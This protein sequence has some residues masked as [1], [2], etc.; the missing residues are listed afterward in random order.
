MLENKLRKRTKK[1][2]WNT[3]PALVFLLLFAVF[4]ILF[5]TSQGSEVLIVDFYSCDRFGNPQDCFAI[6]STAYFNLTVKNL[7]HD[8]KN[9]TIIIDVL[10]ELDV[11]ICFDQLNTSIPGDVS[12]QYIL[13]I[14]IVKWAH[15]GVAT[16]YVYVWDGSAADYETREFYISPEDLTPPLIHLLS[17]EN[18]T[19]EVSTIPLIFTVDERIH[20]TGYSL[21]NIRN[22][23][24]SGNTT[25]RDLTD[26]SHSI[27]AYTND[28]SGNMGC[29]EKLHFTVFTLHD[30]SITDL[31]CSSKETY[32]GRAVNITVSVRNKGLATENSNVT[33]YVNRTPVE[34]LAAIIPPESQTTLIFIWETADFCKD[35]YT[36]SAHV[37]V[38]PGETETSDNDFTDGW[39]IVTALGD[40]DSDFDVDIYDI[41]ELCSIYGCNDS[42]ARF[43]TKCDLNL[44]GVVDLYDVVI[45]C[46]HYG[47]T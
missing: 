46:E 40:V 31:K 26:G 42:D 29:S 19:Y 25:L 20:W 41:V 6:G 30:L 24:I 35:N 37:N 39:I 47:E 38:I 33:T 3:T 32:I 15:V 10:D 8:Q 43:N 28:T 2:V 1:G 14:F 7:T 5:G 17:P 9:L 22:V 18:A 4:R 21:N 16:A 11:L 36:V 45:A 44:D 13:D 23:T 27:I 12:A 34:T